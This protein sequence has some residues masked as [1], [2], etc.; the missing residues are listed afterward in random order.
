MSHRELYHG[1][2]VGISRSN[3]EA[4][5]SLTR[6]ELRIMVSDKVSEFKC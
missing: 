3:L 2:K 4:Y 5:D 1:A 6:L